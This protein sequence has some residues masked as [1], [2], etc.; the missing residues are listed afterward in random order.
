MDSE[1]RQGLEY[2]SKQSPDKEDLRD[3]M[4]QS[5]ASINFDVFDTNLIGSLDDVDELLVTP[6]R[7]IT[8]IPVMPLT[9]S[10]KRS[11]KKKTRNEK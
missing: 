10:Q 1:I 6:P 4:H 3:P 8:P 7:N 11:A 2:V 9:K 5:D